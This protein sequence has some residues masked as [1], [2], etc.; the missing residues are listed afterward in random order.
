MASPQSFMKG[1]EGKKRREKRLLRPMFCVRLLDL[2]SFKL[3]TLRPS[4][5][6][7]RLT[8]RFLPKPQSVE[9][10]AVLDALGG[11]LRPLFPP[12]PGHIGSVK[13]GMKSLGL[14]Y[15]C[16]VNKSRC[17]GPGSSLSLKCKASSSLPPT[18][19]QPRHLRA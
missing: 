4:M 18:P 8:L 13:P 12:A 16:Q 6:G 9:A 2:C 7:H 5:I 1:C 10:K 17:S 14:L 11:S 15:F 19:L 3:T